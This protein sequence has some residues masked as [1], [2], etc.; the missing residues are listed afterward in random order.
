MQG[1]EDTLYTLGKLQCADQLRQ[2]PTPLR[3]LPR[4]LELECCNLVRETV[5]AR[6]HGPWPLGARLPCARLDITSAFSCQ[7]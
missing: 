7:G 4:P 5:D 3:V 6:H 1:H 2:M